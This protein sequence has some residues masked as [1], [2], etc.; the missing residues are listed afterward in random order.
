[1]SLAE[2]LLLGL[3]QG[4]TEFLP[5]SSSA[6]LVLVQHLLGFSKPLVF[7]DVVLHLGTL[8]GL[9]VYFAGDVAHLVRDSI[10][11]I[12][13]LIHRKPIEQI[14]EVAPHSRWALGILVAT[15]PTG[16]AG[17]FFKDWFESLFGSLQAVGLALL[18][19]TLILWLTRYFQKNEKGMDQS[20]YLDYFVIGVFQGIAIIPGI[21]RSGATISAALFRGLKREEAF[22]F[23]FL[24]AV[25]A[26]LGAGLLE[27]KDGL[28]SWEWGWPVLTVGFLV[29]AVFGYLSL[30]FLA[31]IIQKGKLHLFGIYTFLFGILVLVVSSRLG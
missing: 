22:R 12:S 4:L 5:V 3:V 17:F 9:L 8:V 13:Y 6:H 28:G 25:P 23:S 7:F 10:Y 15:I 19:T 30:C 18:G 27:W 24:L 20:S 16:L 1:M 26:I 29:S 31:R 21:S 2:A 11:G 14:S